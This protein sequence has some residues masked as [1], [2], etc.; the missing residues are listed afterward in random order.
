MLET[1]T[2]PRHNLDRSEEDIEMN[3]TTFTFSV[4]A[5]LALGLVG[6]GDSSDN[7]GTGGT[8]GTPTDMAMVRVAHLGTDLP[9]AE[10]TAV[11]VTVDGDVAIEDLTFAWH[12]R[13]RHRHRSVLGHHDAPGR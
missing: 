12:Q 7:N 13:R 5:A 9:T 6:C 4:I 1:S 10:N 3:K 11:D 2:R 8:G